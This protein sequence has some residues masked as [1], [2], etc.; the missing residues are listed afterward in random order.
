MLKEF[1]QSLYLW[2]IWNIATIYKIVLSYRRTYLG[3]AWLM[4]GITMI[5]LAK[6]FLFSG[7]LNIPNERIIPNLAIGMLVWRLLA[8]I[9]NGARNA[10]SSNKANFEQGYLPLF[11]PVLSTIVHHSFMFIHAL[12]PMLIIS[13]YFTIPNLINIW[14]VLPGIILIFFASIPI[15]FIVSVFCARYRDLVNLIH[16]IMGITFFLTPVIWVPEMAVGFREWVLLL[17]PFYHFMELVRDPLVNQ[18]IE[19]LNWIVAFGIGIVAW[20]IS[21]LLYNCYGRRVLIWL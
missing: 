13:F 8:G 4:V 21:Y 15:G 1:I 6:A 17:N 3:T 19:V 5:V 11:T 9:I 14:L 7:I 12:L 20:G 18:P 10:I 16:A 2:R